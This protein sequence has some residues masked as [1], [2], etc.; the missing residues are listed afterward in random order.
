MPLGYTMNLPDLA[1]T[2]SDINFDPTDDIFKDGDQIK[3]NVTVRNEGTIAAS[4]INAELYD[5]DPES[6]SAPPIGS[7]LIPNIPAGG[8]FTFSVP[9]I[10]PQY[11]QY[12]FVYVKVDPSNLIAEGNESNNKAFR[13]FRP[14]ADLQP[15]LAVTISAPSAVNPS[16]PSPNSVY[17]VEGQQSLLSV[18]SNIFNIGKSTE[19]NVK[20][21]FNPQNGLTVVSGPADTTIL[22]ISVGSSAKITWTLSSN[23]DS[24]GYNLYSLNV[25]SDSAAVKEVKRTVIVLDTTAP[26]KP[27]GLAVSLK[28]GKAL[29]GWTKNTETDL[30]GYKIYYGPDGVN[31]NGTGATEGNSPITVSTVNQF[32]ISGLASTKF[33]F[34]IKAFDVSN[35][36]SVFS[37]NVSA[38]LT[39]I[40]DNGAGIPTQYSLYQNYPNPFNPSTIIRYALPFESKVKIMI[41]DILG[42]EVKELLNAVNAAGIH[43]VEFDAKNLTSGIYFYRINA[44]SSDG[45]KIFTNV[46]KLILLK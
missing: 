6:G 22:S 8:S 28:S 23:K 45:S 33:Y 17:K 16:S 38:D 14:N 40:T 32:T 9:A 31:W 41:Y 29:L 11:S 44:V 12:H 27:T 21:K 3:I 10:V 15:P 4:N 39:G 36:V 18:T 42:R 5:G 13:P 37:D 2:G 43:E 19:T 34:A 24:S 35:N 26:A 46:K 1:V 25:G 7:Y 20:V 30:G